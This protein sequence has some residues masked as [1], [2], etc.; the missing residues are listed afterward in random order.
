MARLTHSTLDVLNFLL[1][2]AE[3]PRFGLEI[4]GATGLATGSIY[5]ILARL[6][7]DGWLASQ[8]EAGEA[9][10]LGRPAR[11]LYRLTDEGE[12]AARAELA[13]R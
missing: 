12:V 6:E 5:P 1:E 7:R 3:C 8:W 13:F 2:R 9:A 10:D 11:R 4:S